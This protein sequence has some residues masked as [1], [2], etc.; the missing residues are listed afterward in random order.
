MTT[1]TAASTTNIT[2]R[3]DTNLS[4]LLRFGRRVTVVRLPPSQPFK[5]Q[6]PVHSFMPNLG[7]PGGIVSHQAVDPESKEIFWQ[8]R[9]ISPDRVTGWSTVDLSKGIAKYQ[10]QLIALR[11]KEPK[12]LWLMTRHPKWM[13]L[14]RAGI[15]GKSLG[16]VAFYD[17]VGAAFSGN[18]RVLSLARADGT[19]FLG[20]IKE[21]INGWT[22]DPMTCLEDP[23]VFDLQLGTGGELYDCPL[24][25]D[26]AGE[27]VFLIAHCKATA[28]PEKKGKLPVHFEQRARLWLQRSPAPEQKRRT[29]ACE[30][31]EE[32]SDSSPGKLILM[33]CAKGDSEDWALAV[34]CFEA[35]EATVT[36]IAPG[37]SPL[38]HPPVSRGKSGGYF[39]TSS[40]PAS[41]PSAFA[42]GPSGIFTG[43]V[44]HHVQV[45]GQSLRGTVIPPQPDPATPNPAPVVPNPRALTGVCLLSG[46][47]TDTIA[48]WYPGGVRVFELATSKGELRGRLVTHWQPE[49]GMRVLQVQALPSSVYIYITPEEKPVESS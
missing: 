10:P 9:W 45:A 21:D 2:Q 28:V 26:T 23:Q 40:T 38:K 17:I 24:A 48:D 5:A 46:G 27:H 35:T 25:L 1:K 11:R 22:D 19:V 44:G 39:G 29:V 18:G 32:V 49:A 20:K 4:K 8:F 33:A 3:E 41:T 6:V 15:D 43:V 42:K 16:S 12:E 31:E 14:T 7:E 13:H 37:S 36:A 30:V 47:S 34:T